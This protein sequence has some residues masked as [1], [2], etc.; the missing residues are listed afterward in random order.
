MAGVEQDER[1]IRAWG[2][3]AQRQA[4]DEAS[5]GVHNLLHNLVIRNLE[6]P[7]TWRHV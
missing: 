6:F 5:A 3:E 2:G 1:D 7:E 4:S